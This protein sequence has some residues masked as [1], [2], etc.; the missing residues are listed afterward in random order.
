MNTDATD[1]PRFFYVVH[2]ARI[3]PGDMLHEINDRPLRGGPMQLKQA[4]C[5]TACRGGREGWELVPE[6]SRVSRFVDADAR[7]RVGRITAPQRQINPIVAA[8]AASVRKHK[9][10]NPSRRK[11]DELTLFEIPGA[12]K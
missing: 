2:P 12:T 1:P 7:L 5:V 3:K 11:C 9:R 4:R 6:A 10:R 8:A